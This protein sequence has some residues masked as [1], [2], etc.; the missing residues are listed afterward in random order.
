MAFCGPTT[1]KGLTLQMVGPVRAGTIFI[2]Y[3]WVAPT[4]THGL[5]LRGRSPKLCAPANL[6]W[7]RPRDKDSVADLLGTCNIA[8]FAEYVYVYAL[9]NNGWSRQS[10]YDASAAI[11]FVLAP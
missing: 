7:P 10:Q 3:P 4:A 8:A 9:A 1:L 6:A 11:A 5:P 2:A